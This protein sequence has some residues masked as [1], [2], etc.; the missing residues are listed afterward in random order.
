MQD[1]F[2]DAIVSHFCQ[3]MVKDSE[4]KKGFERFPR[5]RP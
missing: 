1:E 4:L 2:H 3:L 5:E